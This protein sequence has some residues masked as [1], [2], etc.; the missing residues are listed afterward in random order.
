VGHCG[1]HVVER[2]V[3]RESGGGEHDHG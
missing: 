3:N 2:R 1:G